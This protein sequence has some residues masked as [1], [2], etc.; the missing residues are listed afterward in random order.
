MGLVKI[1]GLSRTSGL[2]RLCPAS[3]PILLAEDAARA[4]PLPPPNRHRSSTT[5]ETL[6]RQSLPGGMGHVDS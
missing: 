2:P 3:R 1:A 6:G 4:P 5:N